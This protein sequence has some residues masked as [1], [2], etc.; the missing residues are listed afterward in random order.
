MNKILFG[1]KLEEV[2]TL[3]LIQ[4]MIGNHIYN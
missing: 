3:N 1:E 4:Y 2:D